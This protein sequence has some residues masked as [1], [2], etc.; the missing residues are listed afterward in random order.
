MKEK[1][2][3]KYVEGFKGFCTF[4]YNP[5]DHTVFGRGGASWGKIL[6]FYFFFYSCLAGFFAVCLT[7]MLTTIDPKVPTVVGRT[8]KP[9]VATYDSRLYKINF[10]D[11]FADYQKGIE[12]LKD[13]YTSEDQT[14]V[15][16]GFTWS[17]DTLGECYLSQNTRNQVSETGDPIQACIYVGLNRIYNWSPSKSESFDELS[18]ECNWDA[19][20][21]GSGNLD[22]PFTMAMEGSFD[23]TGY[24]PWTSMEEKGLQ[25]I[26][27]FLI[28]ADATK[29]AEAG[30]Q[31]DFK[32]D[33]FVV[34]NAVMKNAN[35]TSIP[36]EGSRPAE[37]EI[38]Y[39][40]E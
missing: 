2:P 14:K 1:K 30:K 35:G 36:L 25:P 33:T 23:L 17:E 4:L 18:F 12:A 26:S 32:M 6:I 11:K 5:D 38:K 22:P 24:Y 8:N 34:C 21:T 27:A 3:N 13:T 37:F 19:G 7:V 9:M 20:K 29:M 28:K 31:D 10:K 39:S 40:L 16:D 15:T